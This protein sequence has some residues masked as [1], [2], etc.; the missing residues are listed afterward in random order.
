MIIEREFNFQKKS[1][2]IFDFITE[3]GE[4]PKEIESDIYML[5]IGNRSNMFISRIKQA[6]LNNETLDNIYNINTE[7][8]NR[9]RDDVKKNLFL[10]K[11]KNI[12]IG[13]VSMNFILREGFGL[14]K[15]E[16]SSSFY[17]GHDIFDL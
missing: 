13:G 4:E 17:L 15:Y 2:E 6:L 10:L 8:D 3:K 5:Y 11:Y 12:Y 16:N 1:N 14:N 7:E 9:E